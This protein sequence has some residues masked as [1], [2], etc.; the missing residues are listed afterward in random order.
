MTGFGGAG[1]GL[2]EAGDTPGGRF[3]RGAAAAVDHD[4]V[5]TASAANPSI[6]P[7][8][9]TRLARALKSEEL[10]QKEIKPIE[11]VPV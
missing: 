6:K 1:S 3:G 9:R 2:L 10:Q 5:A 8:A 4:N 11:T 7:S